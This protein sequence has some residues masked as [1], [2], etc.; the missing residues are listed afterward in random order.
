MLELEQQTDRYRQIAKANP[1]FEV[2]YE[3]FVG[4]QEE[5]TK[6]ILDFL[7]I[8]IYEPLTDN[9]FSKINPDALD[10]I[11]ENYQEVCQTLQGTKFEELLEQ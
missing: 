2:S 3:A 6:Q 8:P 9:R 1:Y 11:I 10:E 4:N 5:T 7:E